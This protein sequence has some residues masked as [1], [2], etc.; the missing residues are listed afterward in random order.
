MALYSREKARRS[1]FNTIGYRAIS[2]VATLLSYVVL[3]RA[4]S[5]Q[6][7]GILSLFYAFIPVV[8]TVASLGLEQTLRRFQ[9][10][11]L[12]SGNTAASAWLLRVVMI[13]RLTSNAL[14][15]ALI[16]LAWNVVAPFFQL[17]A[18]RP[19]FALFVPLVLLYFQG[20]ILE[21]ALG[22]HMLHRYAVGSTVLLAITKLLAYLA[23]V[24]LQALTLRSA[25]L[26]DTLAYALAYL[27]MRAAYRY[28]ATDS[29]SAAGQ[30][31]PAAEHRRLWRYALFNNF[32]DAGSILLYVQTD[33]FFIAALL[34]PVAVGAYAFY[35]RINAMASNLT[36]L[37]LLENV[38]QPLFFAIPPEQAQERVPRYFTLLVNCSLAVQLPL[39]AYTVVYHREIVDLLLGGKFLD[40]S[41]LL[42]VI[43]AFGTTSNVIALP[44]T[45]V[46]QYRERASLILLSQAFGIYQIAGMLL[47]VP[48][49]GLLGAAVATG[50]YHLFRNL[51]VWWNV[52]RDARWLN[53]RAVVAYGVLIWGGAIA[54][55]LALKGAMAVSPLV[56]LTC[57]AVICAFALIVYVRSPALSRSDR[58][59]L[60][61]LFHGREARLLQRLGLLKA[62]HHA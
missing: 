49:A 20:R 30:R 58:E 6:S 10:E 7:F 16:L 51:F 34:N 47:L 53:F 52:R 25:I 35:T 4:L 45:N 46:A 23:L 27:F 43:L 41:W 19:E 57:G 3:V 8:S 38:V 14:I 37:R 44:V 60:A 18:Y 15:L 5:E 29:R 24:A 48:A 22:S 1:L 2:Q 28:H 61:Q 50:S 39:V 33:N 55:C 59:L 42:P 36:P 12:R 13:T 31:P 21:F 62:A 26:A 56:A 9:P 17:G 32:N 11:Y 40:V 54:A